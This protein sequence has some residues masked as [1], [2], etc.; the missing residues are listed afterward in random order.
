MLPNASIESVKKLGKMIE[1][2]SLSEMSVNIE[3]YL[4]V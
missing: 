3:I 4:A 1:L 2:K